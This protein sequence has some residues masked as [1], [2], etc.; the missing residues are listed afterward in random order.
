[1][2]HNAIIITVCVICGL[3]VVVH[4][5]LLFYRRWMMD[6]FGKRHE[7]TEAKDDEQDQRLVAIEKRLSEGGAL[8]FPRTMKK[9]G[10]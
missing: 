2:S 3:T 4:V 8:Y 5:V 10:A 6:Q 1:M 9:V 7:K